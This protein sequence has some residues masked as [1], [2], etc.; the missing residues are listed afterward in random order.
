[1]GNN[2]AWLAKLRE[3]ALEPELPICDCHHHLWGHRDHPAATRYLLDNL[4]ADID[5]SGHNIVSTVFVDSNAMFRADGDRATAPI[6]EVEFANGVAAMC[7]S[8]LYGKTQ[9]AAGIISHADMR[10]GSAA[11]DVLDAMA[12]AAPARFRGIRHSAAWDADEA[13]PKHR[14]V[15]GPQLLLD[16]SFRAGIAE[17]SRRGLVYE[18]YLWHPQ[19]PELTDLARAFPDLTIICNHCGGPLGAE[20]YRGKRDQVMAEWRASMAELA[21]CENVIVKLGGVNMVVNGHDWEKRE[22]PPTSDEMVAAAGPYIE[23]SIEL[24]GTKRGMFESNYPAERTTAGYG[25][26]WNFF[27]KMTKS[28]SPDEKAALYRDNAVRVYRLER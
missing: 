12:R 15:N 17:V 25:E 6:G 3:P 16:E 24:F 28:F 5:D 7:A 22:Q 26:V 18:C 27:K 21:K 9:V 8:G 23:Q 4:L 11:G 20:S 10:L 2:D 1:M 19:L 14:H 13:F